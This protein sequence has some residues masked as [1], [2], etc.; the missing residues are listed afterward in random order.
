MQHLHNQRN[1]NKKVLSAISAFVMSLCFVVPTHS[2]ADNIMISVSDSEN[3]S[4]YDEYLS[5][6]QLDERWG[7]TPMGYST[8][9]SSGCLIT[10]LAIMIM[11][12]DSVDDVAMQNLGI[13]DIE[14]FN[15]SV[16]ANAY[17]AAN[18]FT[19][20]GAI[21]SWG[22][23]T[24][25]IPQITECKG[26]Q[27]FKNTEKYAVAEE[28][29]SLMN[30]GYYIIA[31]VNN[32][33]FHWVYIQG[34]N[35]DGSVIISDPANDN[36]DLYS[37]YPNGLQG[38]YW[39]LKGK[40]SPSADFEKNAVE[41]TSSVEYFVQND[42]PVAVYSEID[43]G[44]VTA[45]LSSGNVVNILECDGN[46]GLVESSDFT[47]WV[48]I[49]MLAEAE[50]IPQAIGDINNDSVVDKYDLALIN[51]YIQQKNLLPDGVSTLSTAELKAADINCD[52]FVDSADVIEFI[53]LLN[54]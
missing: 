21:A 15:P 7:S 19:S 32:G 45:T 30:D 10:S 17:T 50:D 37:I 34:V 46:Y 31:R 25:L 4:V 42:E 35:E 13:T 29:R 9:R 11:D 3:I 20:G 52:G 2:M 8:I 39:A 16:L 53:K 44:S 43:G 49:S 28:I 51:T 33:G 12:S 41:N 23:I 26:G 36:D 1:S 40:N 24:K 27:Y 18:G 48:D 6:S 47:G 22:T 54:N 14:Q 38:E 5:W